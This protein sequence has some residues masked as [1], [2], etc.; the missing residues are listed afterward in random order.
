MT[1]LKRRLR[2]LRVGDPL[3]KNTDIGA[4]DSA[5]QL[6]R[7]RELS[8][9]G[10]AEG[11]ERWSPPCGLPDRGFWFPHGLHRGFP[12]APDRSRGDLRS[13]AVR[14]DVPDAG[15]GRGE[16]Q[17]H[18]VRAAEVFRPTRVRGSCGWP[19]SSA[20]ASS[21]RTHQPVRP[22]LAVGGYKESGYVRGWPPWARR[23]WSRTAPHERTARRSK[24]YKLAIG[25]SFLR[26]ESGRSYEVLDAKGRFLA[27][28]AMASARMPATPWSLP[29]RHI[30]R[31]Q[32][33]P[34]TTAARS[35]TASPR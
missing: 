35:Y 31:G 29:A 16:G 32:G 15:G 6:A 2:T 7:I 20:P 22:D 10:E 25:G 18:P 13:G 14:T 28:T 1:R 12:G 27:N 9:V 33:P 21:G 26:S 3:D 19:S 11:A 30:R 34:R 24:T 5:E 23:I 17:Q 4:I 8:D